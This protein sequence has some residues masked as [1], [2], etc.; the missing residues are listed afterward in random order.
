[1]KGFR[2]AWLIGVNAA[3]LFLVCDLATGTIANHVEIRESDP[4]FHHGLKAS[5]TET[6]VW[7]AQTFVVN[8]DSLGLRDA[9]PRA[10][11]RKTSRYRMVFVGD[12][13]TEGV[14]VSYENSFVG[15]VAASLDRGRYEV[16]NAGLSSYSPKLYYLKIKYLLEE[17]H[18]EFNELSV[19][20]DISDPQDEVTYRSFEPAAKPSAAFVL[21]S[22]GKR[23]SFVYGHYYPQ[24]DRT[25]LALNAR[26]HRVPPASVSSA[27][28]LGA[29]TTPVDA[30]SFNDYR[31]SW[32]HDSASFD[33]WGR[34]GLQLGADNMDRLYAL[35]RAHQIRL[36][37]AVYPWPQQVVR[38]ELASRQVTFWREFSRER[39]I[40]FLDN[41]PAFIDGRMPDQ[42]VRE[43]FVD[44]DVH[45]NERGHRVIADAFLAWRGLR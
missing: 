2:A 7:G 8:T 34:Q 9:S 19:Y 41:F 14:G 6:F 37:I 26:L 27:G 44:G 25:L 40:P 23:H 22:F 1:V 29:A 3:V 31:A 18:L 12:S 28:V 5:S 38:R 21:H 20:I 15:I 17:E 36:N 32:T 24:I 30:Q 10:V 42:V 4:H 39:N 45:W 33:A 16:L 13:F 35:C 11:E 43:D